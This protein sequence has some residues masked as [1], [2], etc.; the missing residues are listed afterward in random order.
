LTPLRGGTTFLFVN[1]GIETALE[2]ARGPAGDRDVRVAGGG[3]TIVEYVNG[4]WST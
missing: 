2:Q 4:S 1:D 3:A